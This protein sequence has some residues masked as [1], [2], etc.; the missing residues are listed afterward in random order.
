MF[1]ISEEQLSWIKG[2]ISK[3]RLNPEIMNKLEITQEGKKEVIELKWFTKDIIKHT[4]LENLK[5]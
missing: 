4:I 3:E 2:F 1:R 5:Q